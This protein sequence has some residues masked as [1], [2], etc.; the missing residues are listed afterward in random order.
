MSEAARKTKDGVAEVKQK[1]KREE[2]K[3]LPKVKQK[4]PIIYIIG[5]A[6]HRGLVC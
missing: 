1:K 3:I 6:P 4:H 2:E 5:K